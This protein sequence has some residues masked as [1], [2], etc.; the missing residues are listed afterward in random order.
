MQVFPGRRC[1]IGV[2]KM[3]VSKLITPRRLPVF[4]ARKNPPWGQVFCT[5]VLNCDAGPPFQGRTLSPKRYEAIET[6]HTRS[7]KS[8]WPG[9]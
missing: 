3:G 4:R 8:S 2:S 6:P 5:V 1:S 9:V 7:R